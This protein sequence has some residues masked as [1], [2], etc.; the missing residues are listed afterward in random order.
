VNKS[1]FNVLIPQAQAL[2]NRR[3]NTHD[4]KS[5]RHAI[6][7]QHKTLDSNRKDT[8]SDKFHLF[9]VTLWKKL[10]IYL[11]YVEV[12]YPVQSTEN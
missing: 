1:C 2:S 11:F 7:K 10:A 9:L 3:Q 5:M 4:G 12:P 8:F 6:V